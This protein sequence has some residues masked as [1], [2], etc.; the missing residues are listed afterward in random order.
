V[1]REFTPLCTDEAAMAAGYCCSYCST[2][3]HPK[4]AEVVAS[5]LLFTVV[6]PIVGT[7][8]QSIVQS[9]SD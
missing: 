8:V 6:V 2:M 4:L 9:L 3:S 1:S 5:P 7:I